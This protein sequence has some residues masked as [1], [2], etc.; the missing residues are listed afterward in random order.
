MP[1]QTVNNVS[2][3]SKHLPSKEGPWHPVH[4]HQASAS[5][6]GICNVNPAINDSIFGDLI[7]DN[8]PTYT[9]NEAGFES[10]IVAV[11]SRLTSNKHS[12]VNID[13]L[14]SR[15]GV[16]RATD[17]RTLEVTTQQL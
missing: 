15:L 17:I 12:G 4:I 14:T 5:S 3:L 7:S 9:F 2:I 11:V 8:T 1:F 6:Q 16:G 13:N 10:R